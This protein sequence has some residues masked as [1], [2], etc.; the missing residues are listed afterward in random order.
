MT[1]SNSPRS[2]SKRWE[3]S[4]TRI[5][6]RQFQTVPKL[7]VLPSESVSATLGGVLQ[8]QPERTHL[9]LRIGNSHRLQFQTARHFRNA[10]PAPGSLGSYIACSSKLRDFRHLT[11]R[12]PP[13]SMCAGELHR[14]QFQT[15]RLSPPH[16]PWPSPLQVRWGA[17]SPTVPNSCA[18]SD[19]T[20]PNDQC[21][22]P[23]LS[24]SAAHCERS[25]RSTTSSLRD[26]ESAQFVGLS[27][28]RPGKTVR[29]AP[30]PLELLKPSSK[31]PT[32]PTNPKQSIWS[33]DRRGRVC[34]DR[35][36]R[37]AHPPRSIDPRLSPSLDM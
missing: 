11:V 24:R 22:L 37:W 35:S 4:A 33:W 9:I 14:L 13:R 23:L 6:T 25:K 26:P 1:P 15:A 32:F 31:A 30:L 2:S 16:G 36:S 5:H 10:L 19:D 3:G 28:F 20:V 17:T 8:A 34:H 29:V 27:F 12:G 7:Q 21:L 18:T